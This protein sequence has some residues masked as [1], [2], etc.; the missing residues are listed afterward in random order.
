M[1][2]K[3]VKRRLRLSD[4]DSVNGLKVRSIIW[5]KRVATFDPLSVKDQEPDCIYMA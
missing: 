1:E 2:R 4:D 3:S 5:T